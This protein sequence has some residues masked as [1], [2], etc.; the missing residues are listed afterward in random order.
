MLA[1]EEGLSINCIVLQTPLK[2]QVLSVAL[3]NPC[4][5]KGMWQATPRGSVYHHRAGEDSSS[6]L[7]LREIEMKHTPIV[8]HRNS[9]N[10]QTVTP[11][12]AAKHPATTER[13]VVYRPSPK[14]G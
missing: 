11:Q 13:E 3:G 5:P 10:G 14:K 8:I 2:S 7:T 1:F 6:L 12:Y 9:K 4:L